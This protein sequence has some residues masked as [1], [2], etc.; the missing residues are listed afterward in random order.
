[1][2]FKDL[3][4]NGVSLGILLVILLALWKVLTWARPIAENLVRSHLDL[5]A[6]LKEQAPQQTEAL[7]QQTA[8]IKRVGA[9]T[10]E[11]NSHLLKITGT[12]EQLVREQTRAVEVESQCVSGVNAV[13]AELEKQTAHMQETAALL[14]ERNQAG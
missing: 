9:A 1:M 14:A 12:Q 2:E 7:N 5:I 11:Q 13:R 6:T 4:N 3:F 10:E 8:A